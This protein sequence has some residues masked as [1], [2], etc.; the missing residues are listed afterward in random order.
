M[1]RL[2]AL[3]CLTLLLGAVPAG[4]LGVAVGHPGS[5]VDRDH[6]G[7]TDQTDDNCPDDA[8]PRQEDAD[9][10]GAGDA[11]DI[12]DDADGVDDAI[13]TCPM[14]ENPDQ[15]DSDGDGTGDA[16]DEDDDGD[17]VRDPQDTCPLLANPDQADADDDFIG[18]ACDPDAPKRG[19]GGLVADPNDKRGPRLQVVLP[20]GATVGDA[21]S[22][23][24]VEVR[25]D[26]A[27]TLAGDLRRGAAT[28]GRDTAAMQ[29]AGTTYLF[30]RSRSARRG[31]VTVR[32]RGTDPSGNMTSRTRSTTLRR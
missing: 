13:D 22:G 3:L 30:L 21:R 24:V 16:C 20:R 19:P 27:C 32:V 6:D 1:L 17:A 10:D 25:C 15:R 5:P 14:R 8:N 23:L 12:D 18:D 26:E 4:T 9:R 11:C 28:I 29:A 31:K 7:R 2:V